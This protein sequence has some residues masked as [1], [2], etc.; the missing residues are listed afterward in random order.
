MDQPLSRKHRSV[1]DSSVILC[2][3]LSN[4]KQLPDF[5]RI[6]MLSSSGSFQD[7]FLMT[8]RKLRFSRVAGTAVSSRYALEKSEER[9]EQ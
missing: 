5:R 2:Y 6:L 9:M 8:I 7:P 1:K 4:G 3:G